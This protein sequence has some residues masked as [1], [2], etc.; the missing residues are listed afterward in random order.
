MYDHLDCEVKSPIGHT[1]KART[2]S[3]LSCNDYDL[4][5]DAGACQ[6]LWTLLPQ[7][8]CHLNHLNHL[9]LLM[10]PQPP[11][12]ATT[13]T[14]FAAVAGACQA[15]WMLLP[16]HHCHLNHLNHLLLLMPP[17]PPT[18]NHL[19][20]QPPQPP[21]PPLLLLQALAKH[22]GCFFLNITASSIM[23]KWLGDASR[24]VRAIFSL[25]EKLQPCIIFIGA[26]C[27]LGA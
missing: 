10:P 16:Q 8:H 15:L 26:C 7:H 22:S 11:T 23:S 19:N 2:Y 21:Q 6:A 13:S 1:G 5:I 24:L 4:H 9:L 3:G 20:H 12:T 14:T 18:T 17:Q 25:A 27:V